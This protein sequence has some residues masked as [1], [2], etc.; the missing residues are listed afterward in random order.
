MPPGPSNHPNSPKAPFILWRPFVAAWRW[1]A[2]STQASRDR[3]SHTS[4]F[5]GITI[6]TTA[7]VLLCTLAILY[8]RPLYNA[9]QDW[10]ANQL[11][12]DARSLVDEG[13]L[14]PAIMAAQEAYTL[15]P[16]NIAAIR[17]GASG[18]LS[19]FSGAP[20][21][22]IDSNQ[23]NPSAIPVPRRKWRLEKREDFIMAL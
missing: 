7:S 19:W 20:N 6:V 18:T 11:I 2:P 21:E 1:L 17:R 23:G 5:V 9:W 13:E 8:A 10:R 3:Q 16:E 14:L 22:E 12:A 15:S 4:R